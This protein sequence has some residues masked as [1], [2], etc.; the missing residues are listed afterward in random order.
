MIQK[1]MESSLRELWDYFRTTVSMRRLARYTYVF[2]AN[3]SSI[4]DYNLQK[5]RMGNFQYTPPY[6]YQP[7]NSIYIATITGYFR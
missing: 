1:Q 2:V 5:G 7:V 4:G 6:D 3:L